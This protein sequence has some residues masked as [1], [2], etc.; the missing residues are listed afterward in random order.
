M[1]SN[2]AILVTVAAIVVVV[3]V[4]FF[5]NR[6]KEPIA[7]API[8][9]SYLSETDDS[10]VQATFADETVTFS[11]ESTG[12][13]VLPQVISASGARYANADESIIF[14]E[15]GGEATITVEGEVVFQGVVEAPEESGEE[16]PV[17]KLPAGSNPPPTR[18]EVEGYVWVWEKTV[19][20]TG[21]VIEP[22]KEGEFTLSFDSENS[23]SGTT[24][25]NNFGGTASVGSD[26]VISF[27]ALMSTK[28]F[29][30]GSQEEVF[31]EMIAATRSYAIDASG[32]LVLTLEGN[33][34]E[35]FFTK[36]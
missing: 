27:G 26:G 22:A 33:G 4:Y 16:A 35:V 32:N 1:M 14:W 20:S 31:T 17:G 9:A 34:G 29:C 2:K 25:C 10:Q 30:E 13:V 24:D 19:M 36:Q 12:Q 3:G 5:I 23:I 21:V 18:E 8:V 28:M 15:K 11:H 6:E 7:P